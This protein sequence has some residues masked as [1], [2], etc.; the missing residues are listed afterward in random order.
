MQSGAPHH[1]SLRGAAD[2]GLKGKK[3]LQLLNPLAQPQQ[4]MQILMDSENFPDVL[5]NVWLATT[6]MRL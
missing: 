2:G 3:V 6:S 1:A 5:D 4:E